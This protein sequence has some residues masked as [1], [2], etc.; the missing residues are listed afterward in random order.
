MFDL[1]DMH[2]AD[3]AG[4]GDYV[5]NLFAGE[6]NKIIDDFSLQES[7]DEISKNNI[8]FCRY[9]GDEFC[10]SVVNQNGDTSG[11]EDSIKQK[12]E[13][14]FNDINNPLYGYYKKGLGEYD[15]VEKRKI[16]L[17]NENGSFIKTIERPDSTDERTVFDDFFEKGHILSP[18]NIKKASV[19]FKKKS[20]QKT[21]DDYRYPI[22]K[23]GSEPGV[24][25]KLVYIKDRY[26]KLKNNIETIL[27]GGYNDS[28]KEQILHFLEERL[29]DRMFG[30]VVYSSSEFSERLGNY[31][32]IY[33]IDLKAVKELNELTSYPEADKAIIG[34]YDLI[35][36][37]L[38]D[39]LENQVDIARRGG[40]F[41][42]GVKNEAPQNYINAPSIKEKLKKIANLSQSVRGKNVLF[43][44]GVSHKKSKI[45][46]RT[47]ELSSLTDEAELDFYRKTARY[48]VEKDTYSK[49]NIDHIVSDSVDKKLD[50]KN[51]LLLE[52]FFSKRAFLRASKML[53]AIQSEPDFSGDDYNPLRKI[54]INIHQYAL[55]SFKSDSEIKQTEMFKYVL[56]KSSNP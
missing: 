11:M 3:K 18:E 32:N 40:S 30:S 46:F 47:E 42:I 34:L 41:Y 1:K 19:N 28:E 49:T 53:Q 16:E 15:P 21:R 7:S 35:R 54:M 33:C 4:A 52:F 55:D 5:L 22:K 29:F 45:G 14:R 20:D 56:S 24:Y 43:D 48:L 9:G 38:G 10:V 6:I 37:N 39:E 23:D 17:K 25:D 50:Y 26:P 44:L 51:S 27:K 31:S 13:K 2:F 36:E 8:S 12:I